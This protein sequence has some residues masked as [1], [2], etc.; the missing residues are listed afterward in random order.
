M[1]R[2]R[3]P[4]KVLG[5]VALLLSTIG[6]GAGVMLVVPSPALA[7]P[8]STAPPATW[9]YIENTSQPFSTPALGGTAYGEFGL[10]GV[11]IWG[12]TNLSPTSEALS[13]Q[14]A[15]V[16]Q[17][18]EDY[19]ISSCSP[20]SLEWNTSVLVA[21][22]VSLVEN[23]SGP[24]QVPLSSGSVSALSLTSSYGTITYNLTVISSH[25]SGTP[26]TSGVDIGGKSSYVTL[27]EDGSFSL[28]LDQPL[29]ILPLSLVP[30]ASFSASAGYHLSG[31]VSGHYDYRFPAGFN[32][33]NGGG[34]SH[35]GTFGPEDLPGAQGALSLSLTEGNASIVGG[36]AL[37]TLSGTVLQGPF[38]F[39]D[40]ALV[41]VPLELFASGKPFFI[42][43]PALLGTIISNST[44]VYLGPTAGGAVESATVGTQYLAK[45]EVPLGPAPNAST[46]SVTIFSTNVTGSPDPVS[47]AADRLSGLTPA[48]QGVLPTA[49]TPS[50]L[51]V[52]VWIAASATFVAVVMVSGP[53]RKRKVLRPSV[54]S[55]STVP[56]SPQGMVTSAHPPESK[57]PIE[58]VW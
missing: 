53:G 18:A 30:G 39:L 47:D 49:S 15:T 57:D 40:G 13:F 6:A 14:G 20:A 55:A 22:S 3:A 35:R 26:G 50:S 32:A 27:G 29:P 21:E 44:T 54:T 2:S 8:H 1:N 56:S 4:G 43:P 17:Y 5:V 42:Q 45:M 10:E 41:P 24:M 11:G 9:A 23:L 52:D 38:E 46:R 48:P 25:T 58:N 51:A 12:Q 37:G 28:G 7:V 16:V 34:T 36:N 31:S 19:C 33:T